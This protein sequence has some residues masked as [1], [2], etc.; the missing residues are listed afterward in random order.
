MIRICYNEGENGNLDEDKDKDDGLSHYY[1]YVVDCGHYYH[2]T[3][4]VWVWEKGL[5]GRT[6]VLDLNPRRSGCF[7]AS[8]RLK[9]K[10]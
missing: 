8:N 3:C 10:P 7:P 5:D 1:Y 2:Y 6:L 4:C 9:K